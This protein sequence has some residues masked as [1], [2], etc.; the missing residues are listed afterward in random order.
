[1]P[2]HPPPLHPRKTDPTAG[3]AVS[4]TCVPADK[5]EEQLA[6]QEMPVGKDMIVPSPLPNWSSVKVTSLRAKLAV[7]VVGV[8]MSKVQLFVPEH[9][10]PL[11]PVKLEAELGFAANVNA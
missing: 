10:P 5:V 4:I 2:L 7:T 1:M 9:P 3:E 11:H 8:F 6:L